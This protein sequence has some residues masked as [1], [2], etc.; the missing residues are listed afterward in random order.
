MGQVVSAAYFPVIPE[1]LK[2]IGQ[3]KQALYNGMH[4][5]MQAAALAIK[6]SK[7][8]T[9]VILSRYRFTLADAIGI[10]PQARLRGNLESVGDPTIS[11]GYDT[12]NIMSKEIRR[13]ANRMGIPIVDI[14]GT[15]PTVYHDDH[16]LHTSAVLPLH[17]LH[18]A[19]IGNKQIVR[20][21][22]GRLSYEELFALG[23]TM[24]RAAAS[25]NKK[26]AVITAANL[27]PVRGVTHTQNNLESNLHLMQALGDR[28]GAMLHELGYPPEEEYAI[29]SAAFI[30]GSISGLKAKP[31]IYRYETIA[32]IGYGLM[33]YQIEA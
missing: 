18:E 25:A 27:L 10:S 28:K 23:Q 7:P 4:E 17:Y 15:I 31:N 14:L 11:V 29:R 19:G 2:S 8:Q 5:T 12:D 33:Q 1:A 20:L 24:Q 30:L 9:I 22:M 26:I 6:E 3:K 16:L 21:T 13:F 32:Y